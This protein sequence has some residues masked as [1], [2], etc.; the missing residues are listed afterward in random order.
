MDLIKN[1]T[2]EAHTD[3]LLIAEVKGLVHRDWI[4]EVRYITRWANAAVDH[5]A[6]ASL[7]SMSG[8]H[9][10]SQPAFS[11]ILHHT[12][13]ILN[14]TSSLAWLVVFAKKMMTMTKVCHVL[15]GM[16]PAILMVIVQMAYAGLN[17]LYKLAVNDGM[18]LRVLIAYR[19]IFA[20][21]SMAPL[22]LI[23]EWK[24]MPK[25]TWKILF[26][27]FL[28]GL[29]G[30]TVSQNFYLEAFALKSATFASAMGNL[31]P[32]ITFIMTVSFRLEK[33]NIPTLAGKAKI[34]GTITALSGAMILTFFKGVKI[35][36]GSFHVTLLHPRNGH[37][38]SPQSSSAVKTLLAALCSLGSGCAY[39]LWL[40]IQT[41][42][43]K[44]YPCHYS[45]TALMSF[46]GALTSTVFALC[47]ERDWSQW[48]LGW[49]IRLL[50]AAYTGIIVSGG[51]TVVMTWCVDLSGPL[52]VSAFSPL[53]LVFVA[54]AGFLM[55]DEKLYLGSII[56]GL[57]IVGGLYAVLWGK[58]KEMKKMN[59]LVPSQS[60]H[61]I[62]VTAST[63]HK[64][65]PHNNNDRNEMDLVGDSD[66]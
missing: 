65:S 57:L 23:L 37:V 3:R 30:G 64:R 49:N 46:S 52:Y 15:H 45:S 39:S 48:K 42:M 40:I 55:L 19:F 6:K 22:A 4:V 59:R 62:T 53:T 18:S 50:A 17:V 54:I 63:E 38:A 20:S 66:H 11:F 28:C 27:A 21:A 25:M 5:L 26:Q 2:N 44:N 12:I 47:L 34:I 24:R 1:E 61:E 43:S 51:M 41:K 33:L 13:S 31:I 7:S 56:G 36:T 16:K 32:V 14:L 58:G 29:F 10:L 35:D 8:I 9:I 60:L